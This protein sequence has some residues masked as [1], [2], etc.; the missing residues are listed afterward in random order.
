MTAQPAQPASLVSGLIFEAMNTK[1][2]AILEPVLSDDVVF[3]FPGAGQVAGKKR[4]MVFLKALLRKFPDIIFQV[5]D[6]IADHDK[7]CIVWTNS[8][9]LDTSEPYRNS[10]VTLVHC[11]MG[12]ITCISDYFKDTSFVTAAGT[13]SA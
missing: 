9:R 5:Q 10:G 3:D 8:A 2:M 12:R 13:G 7:A 1:N 11:D 6:V 4:V